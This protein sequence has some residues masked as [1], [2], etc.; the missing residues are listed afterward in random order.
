M[1]ALVANLGV[2]TRVRV[3]VGERFALLVSKAVLRP[4]CSVPGRWSLLHLGVGVARLAWHRPMMP[5][6]RGWTVGKH[7]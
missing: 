3:C 2:A 5:S 1:R 4:G 7:S 6:G